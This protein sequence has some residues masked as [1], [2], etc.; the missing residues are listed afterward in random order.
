MA[1][2]YRH[3]RLDKNEP[4]Y[5]G[6]ADKNEYRLTEKRG[7]NKIWFNIINKTDYEAEILIDNLTWEQALEKEIE[8]ISLYGRI[9]INTGCLANMTIGGEGTIGRKYIQSKQHKEKLSKAAV[10]KKMSNT[11]KE[12]MSKSQK[13]PILQYDLTGNF[14]KEWDG[15]I[16]AAKSMGKYSTNIMRCCRGNF[17]QAYGFVW[18]YKYP[19]LKGRKIKNKQIKELQ[20]QINK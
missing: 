14:I 12:K 2:L 17:K 9:D 1:Y 4:F 7:R 3:I 18:K 10:G 16:D 15:I 5:I 6:I 13:L 20:S 19:E 11:C 8:F